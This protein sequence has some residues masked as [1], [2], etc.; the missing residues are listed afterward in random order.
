MEDPL[1][2]LNTVSADPTRNFSNKLY[3][4]ANDVT[5]DQYKAILRQNRATENAIEAESE[6]EDEN[7]QVLRNNR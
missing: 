3:Q 6:S 1:G 4:I 7:D 5:S 2:S